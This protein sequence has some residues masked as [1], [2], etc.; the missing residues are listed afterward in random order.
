MALTIVDSCQVTGGVDTHLD[1]HVAAAVD[2]IGGLLGVEQ[3]PA[4]RAGYGELLGW[5]AGF[6]PVGRVGVEGTGSYGVGLAR[7]LQAAGVA[8]VEVRRPDREERRRRGKSDPLDAVAAA[9]A[10]LSGRAS[11]APKGGDGPVE[12]MRALLVTKRSARRARTATV[13]QLRALVCTAPDDLRAGLAG[14]GT[15][16]LVAQ[17]AGLRARRGDPAAET[18][19]L[20]LRELGRRARYLDQEIARVDAALLPLVTDRAPGL[21]ALLGV[22]PDTAATLLVSAGDHPQRLRSEA[23]FAQLCGVAPLPASSGKVVRHRL[24][25]GGDR[26]ANRALWTIV[27]TRMHCD[28][29]TRAYVERRTG[30]GKSKPEIVR[31]LKRYVARSIYPELGAVPLR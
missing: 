12:A 27:I 2:G 6:G 19:R 29:R 16:A 22:G 1:V 26:Q 17:A 24:N 9:R 13:N 4:T 10:T 18:T 8:V 21:L 3:F 11:G 28:P 23:A 20:V 15:K 7:W 5:L 14:R 31:C 30:E 25:G